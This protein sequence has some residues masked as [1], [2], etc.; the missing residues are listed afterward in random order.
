MRSKMLENLVMFGALLHARDD[1]P[2]ARLPWFGNT[3]QGTIGNDGTF[4]DFFKN[5]Q[6]N[7]LIQELNRYRNLLSSHVGIRSKRGFGG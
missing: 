1:S 7:Q 5:T 3:E 2:L 6:G 4:G